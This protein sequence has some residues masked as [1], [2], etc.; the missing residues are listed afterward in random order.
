[1][2]MIGHKTVAENV[3]AKFIRILLEKA[4]IDASVSVNEK[5]VLHIITALGNMVRATNSNR[6]C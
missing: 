2:N 3:N 4:Q 5:D 1:M 6:S